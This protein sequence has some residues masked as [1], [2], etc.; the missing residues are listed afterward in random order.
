MICHVANCSQF[1]VKVEVQKYKKNASIILPALSD[2]L[3]ASDN[4]RCLRAAK[5]SSQ[6]IFRCSWHS[7]LNY[8]I[9][10]LAPSQPANYSRLSP[11]RQADRQLAWLIGPRRAKAQLELVLFKQ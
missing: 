1:V 11:V 6:S 4:R 5:S 10:N 3:Q 9:L 7:F 8:S 2:Y